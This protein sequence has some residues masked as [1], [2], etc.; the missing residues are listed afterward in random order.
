MEV[1]DNAGSSMTLKEK[2]PACMGLPRNILLADNDEWH[3]MYGEAPGNGES[4][5]CG[6]GDK[7]GHIVFRQNQN[8]GKPCE[9]GKGAGNGGDPIFETGCPLWAMTGDI[10]RYRIHKDASHVPNL[11]RSTSGAD[12]PWEIVA[13]GIDDLQI[14]YRH[15]SDETCGGAC[16][17]WVDDPGAIVVDNYDSLVQ[18]VRVD[19]SAR[20]VGEANLAGQT[21]SVLDVGGQSNV[22]G[23]LVTEIAP[24]AA[25]AFLASFRHEG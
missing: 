6:G 24:R 12:G 18:R 25:Q 1:C 16:P 17:R 5:S 20:V 7:N 22:R 13:R 21:K 11:E 2:I 3:L 19:L 8:D 14:S 10:V 15:G 9:N 23:R 4:N